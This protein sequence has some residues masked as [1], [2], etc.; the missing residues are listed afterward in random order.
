MICRVEGV[1]VQVWLHTTQVFTKP[2]PYTDL[3]EL[4]VVVGM[5]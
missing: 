3:L 1:Q 4:A 5:C 2:S